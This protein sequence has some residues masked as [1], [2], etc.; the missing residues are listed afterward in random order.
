MELIVCVCACMPRPN[1]SAKRRLFTIV[2][3][4]TCLCVKLKSKFDHESMGY[5][6]AVLSWPHDKDYMMAGRLTEAKTSCFNFDALSEIMPN[7]EPNG[8]LIQK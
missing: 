4:L 5:S 8:I 7:T 2:S 3:S 1:A 6:V